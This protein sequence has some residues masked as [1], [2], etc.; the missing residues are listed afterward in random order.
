MRATLRPLVAEFLGTYALVFIGAGA[1]I[2]DARTSGAVG[3]VGV[4][5]ATSM[6]F[7]VWVT[8]AQRI[9]GAHFNPAITFSLWA[10][11]H[12]ELVRAAQYVV[13]QLAGAV[14]AAWCLKLLF[15]AAAG[16]AVDY[17]VP[18]IAAGLTLTKAILIEAILTFFLVSAVYAT[19]ISRDAPAVG[20][21]AI[22][23][24]V[25]FDMLAGGVL[26]GA[27]MNP[28][29][30]F[31]P[32]VASGFYDNWYVYWVGPLIGAIVAAVLYRYLFE[33][34]ESAT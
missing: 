1:I 19:T 5:L 32:A 12:I 13:V 31:G 33:S 6:V 26:T 27:A 34:R 11:R 30:W 28:A 4:A 2:V 7:G 15:P 20:G 16:S 23:L 24:V 22:G 3:V 10:S 17:G 29:R 25:L 18:R 9:S 14:F 8:L 21:F